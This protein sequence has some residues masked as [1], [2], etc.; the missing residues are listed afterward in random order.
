MDYIFFSFVDIAGES[1][2]PIG[3]IYHTRKGLPIPLELYTHPAVLI[4]GR[5]DY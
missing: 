1:D 4:P 3:S 5:K 2:T